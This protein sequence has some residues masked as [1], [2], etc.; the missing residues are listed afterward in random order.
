[1]RENAG[2]SSYQAGDVLNVT[3]ADGHTP[4]PETEAIQPHR[5]NGLSAV[6]ARDQV[7]ATPGS[8]LIVAVT[9]LDVF[10]EAHAVEVLVR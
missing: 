5:L 2:G 9:S 6:V 7:G 3:L 8:L 1:R 10:G 4:L